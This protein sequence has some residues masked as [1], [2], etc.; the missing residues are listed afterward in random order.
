M[1][2]DRRLFG[3]VLAS[4][5]AALLYT[6]ASP[7]LD[8]SVLAWLAPASLLL[9]AER[10][11][12]WRAALPGFVFGIVI[13]AGI[14]H[15]AVS[16]SL[17]YF[18]LDAITSFA[19]ALLVWVLYSGV[20][21]ALLTAAYA[22]AAK[23]L[24]RVLHPFAA[25]WL[26]VVVEVL[27]SVPPVGMPWGLLSHTQWQSSTVIQIADL[28]GAYAV[29]A[30]VVLVSTAL[31]LA[32]RDGL[33][34]RDRQEPLLAHVSTACAALALLFLYG[35]HALERAWAEQAESGAARI[36]VV[37]GGRP[38]PYRWK[39]SFFQRELLTYARLTHEGTAG[40][41][42]LD[43]VVWPENAVNFYLDS[44]PVLRAQLGQ[45]AQGLNAPLVV[46]AP[47]L[48]DPST[49]HNSAYL[50]GPEG[51]IEEAYDK[52]ILVPFA[53]QEILASDEPQDGPRYASGSSGAPLH[54][55][56]FEL[57]TMICYEVLFPQLVR[58]TV[59]RGASL[60]VNISNDS[61]MDGGDGAA[62]LQH[63]SMSVLRAVET[64]RY[65]VRSSSGGISG[66]VTP[67]GETF[68][69][70][71]H[72]SARA[73]VGDVTPRRELT[74]YVRHGETWIVVAAVLLAACAF[75]A[76]RSAS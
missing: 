1:S 26:W 36:A 2:A 61:W 53:E 31:G 23:R 39:R 75:A 52:Q 62:S 34:R 64:R 35:M 27:R 19:F 14:T 22:A 42:S 41:P 15:W 49:A 59:R 68:A 5:A 38:N 6:L 3:P 73:Q 65:L 74:P 24:P 67:A 4:T 40:T 16:A 12:P 7:P 60:L 46:G 48:S 8:W 21:Y 71:P 13:A 30:L 9:P 69:V 32:L 20:P 58:D 10:L 70:V 25:A 11:S 43:L 47:R 45:I 72:G 55:P 54:A 51:R 18:E 76:H 33:L 50:I 57:G 63:F 66:F 37:Q 29:T 17:R 56:G 44:E 28:G